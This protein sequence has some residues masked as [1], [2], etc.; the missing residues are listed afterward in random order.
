MRRQLSPEQSLEI[1]S[2][3]TL[4]PNADLTGALKE[5]LSGI[6]QIYPAF[7]MRDV[8]SAWNL[9]A[10]GFVWDPQKNK[11]FYGL[12]KVRPEKGFWS[13]NFQASS[14]NSLVQEAPRSS[15][16][17]PEFLSSEESP[18]VKEI[19]SSPEVKENLTRP[20]M[21]EAIKQGLDKRVTAS[22]KRKFPQE[23]WEDLLSEVGLL[24]SLW[25]E[26]GL[27]DSY[28]KRGKPPTVAILAVWAAQKVRQRVYADAT[29]ALNREYKGL[30]TQTEMRKRRELKME[31]LILEEGT[32][33]DSSAPQTVWVIR[34]DDTREVIVVS[35]EVEEEALPAETEKKLTLIRDYIR[36]KRKRSSD[37]YARVFDFLK[38]GIPKQEAA[39]LEGCSVLTISHLYQKVREDLKEAPK[40]L[41]IVLLLLKKISEE[42]YLTLGEIKEENSSLEEEKISEALEVL[43]LGD[44]IREAKGKSFFPTEAGILLGEEVGV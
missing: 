10:P 42:P 17:L 13:L 41:G 37:R 36:V 8:S 30:R 26:R 22:I 43:L 12:V 24:L 18:E 11:L 34:E 39:V 5:V 6:S 28:I 23:S 14:E 21:R 32:K 29:D 7:T 35:P 16:V 1:A 2:S 27:C 40:V 3:S 38:K 4:D 25:G 33:A 20:W 31:D 44:L 19:L 9:R 15:P